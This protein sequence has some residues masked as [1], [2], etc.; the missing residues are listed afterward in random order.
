MRMVQGF[1]AGILGVLA[2]AANATGSGGTRT[3]TVH[4]THRQTVRKLSVLLQS[5]HDRAN[6]LAAENAE[7]RR[8]LD[9][10][11]KTV[12]ALVN[13]AARSRG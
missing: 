2:G 7:L 6:R 13:A 5:E 4:V 8:Q 12:S 3:H 1:E 11:R 9:E 10:N